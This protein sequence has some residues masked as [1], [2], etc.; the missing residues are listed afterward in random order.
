MNMKKAGAW[1]GAVV[2]ILSI[3]STLG[4]FTYNLLIGD[5][6]KRIRTDMA[7]HS[8]TVS[9]KLDALQKLADTSIKASEAR[10]DE[11][12]KHAIE[13]RGAIESLRNEVRIRH[14]DDSSAAA[15][16]SYGSVPVPR[17]ERVT[18]VADEADAH[19]RNARVRAPRSRPLRDTM[20]EMGAP[21]DILSAEE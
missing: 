6:L 15:P 10:F 18:A 2:G 9:K 21:V 3:V 12:E 19:L 20:H 8:A 4:P 14:E 13:L 1:I 17:A 16:V 11:N 7:E 5:E